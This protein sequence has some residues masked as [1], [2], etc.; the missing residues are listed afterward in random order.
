MKTIQIQL[1]VLCDYY[2]A[3][4]AG[5][6]VLNHVM[7]LKS[8][9]G[10]GVLE[11]IYQNNTNYIDLDILNLLRVEN[12]TGEDTA[13]TVQL[14]QEYKNSNKESNF[15]NITIDAIVR[16]S[17]CLASRLMS[18][19]ASHALF[20][21][22]VPAPGVIT[23]ALDTVL[24]SKNVF[25]PNLRLSQRGSNILND[26]LSG[27]V[28]PIASK[29]SASLCM[30]QCSLA[31]CQELLNDLVK[32]NV[33]NEETNNES[34]LHCAIQTKSLQKCQFAFGQVN[35]CAKQ[36][37]FNWRNMNLMKLARSLKCSPN[38]LSLIRE[39]FSMNNDD[40]CHCLERSKSQ[41]ESI[42]ECYLVY[43]RNNLGHPR[44]SK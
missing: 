19:I 18:V 1:W 42:A 35:C 13:A 24:L 15:I 16:N 5:R 27:N 8:E 3:T 21:S 28:L 11:T 25:L 41:G 22:L 9:T 34:I 23:G 33:D 31:T 12:Y 26:T 2:Y 43:S 40:V 6:T 29:Y 32:L 39:T 30:L 37:N 20:R 7:T 14:L 38:I 36:H 4:K 44:I 17:Q 10:L